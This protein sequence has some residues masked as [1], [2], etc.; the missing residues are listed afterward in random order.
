MEAKRIDF[1]DGFR[2]VAILLVLFFHSYVRWPL[3]VPYGNKFASITLFKYG[4]LGV[5]LFFLLSGFVILMS[6][7]KCKNFYIFIYKRWIRLFPAMLIATAFIYFTSTYLQERPNGPPELSSLLPGVLFVEPYWLKIITGHSFKILEGSFWSLFVEV[8][9]YFIFGILYFVFNQNRAILGLLI[10]YFLS[11]YSIHFH[12]KYIESICTYLSFFYFSW[13]AIGALAYIFYS[14]KQIK[15]LLFSIGI[16]C[17]EIYA[18]YFQELT[19]TLY[20][21]CIVVLFFIP[22]CFEKFRIITNSKFLLWLGFISYPLYLIHEN[23]MISLIIKLN[24]ICPSI[25]GL[26]LPIIPIAFLCCAAY[27]IAKKVEPL[28]RKYI[29]YLLKPII[30]KAL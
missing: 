8:K 27:I 11:I 24:R 22:I 9:F 17:F 30:T 10:L 12:I 4:Y 1:L 14:T 20:I 15:Y 6:L 3:I 23:A 18:N 21:I 7:N 19:L 29:D 2:G 26:L 13:F 25:P 28:L 16:S 5:E